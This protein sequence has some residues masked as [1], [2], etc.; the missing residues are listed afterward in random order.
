M[1]TAGNGTSSSV[2]AGTYRL[3]VRPVDQRHRRQ[4]Q[5]LASNYQ[6]PAT[7]TLTID[8]ATLTLNGSKAY[9]GTTTFLA[10]AFGTQRHDRHRHQR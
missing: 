7:G 3:P 6:L 5:D 1:V 8:K 10:S 9:D 4:R 2:N